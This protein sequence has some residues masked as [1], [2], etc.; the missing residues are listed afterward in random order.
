MDVDQPSTYVHEFSLLRVFGHNKV[1][2]M[3]VSIG[4]LWGG[5]PD[6]PVGSP[7]GGDSPSR[8]PGHGVAAHWARQT[9]RWNHMNVD[10]PTDHTYRKPRRILVQLLVA[11]LLL[12]SCVYV[13]LTTHMCGVRFRVCLCVNF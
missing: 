2:C 13:G 8:P 3:C 11:S 9:N 5:A 6:P 7:L 4:L 10:Q 1:V 12:I